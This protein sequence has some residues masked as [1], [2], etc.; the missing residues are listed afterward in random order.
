MQIFGEIPFVSHKTTPKQQ[1]N[2]YL[3]DFIVFN[4]LTIVLCLGLVLES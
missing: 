2:D 3:K 4:R 1:I